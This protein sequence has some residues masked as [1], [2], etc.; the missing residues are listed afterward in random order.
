M[1]KER[2]SIPMCRKE[3]NK[4][5]SGPSH[6]PRK[7]RHVAPCTRNCFHI[8]GTPP[9]DPPNHINSRHS[10]TANLGATGALK[11]IFSLW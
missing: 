5:P 2:V 10:G 9:L 3:V 4:R 8:M 1:W 6:G 7:L 11:K